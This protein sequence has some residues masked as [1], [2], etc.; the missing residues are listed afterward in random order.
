MYEMKMVAHGKRPMARN[1]NVI[2]ASTGNFDVEVKSI[3]VL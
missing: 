2:L 3:T 1:L